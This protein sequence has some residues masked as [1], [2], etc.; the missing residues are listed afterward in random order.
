MNTSLKT[1]RLTDSTFAQ[2]NQQVPFNFNDLS[3]DVDFISRVL[4]QNDKTCV[5]WNLLPNNFKALG[6]VLCYPA[7]RRSLNCHQLQ[8]SCGETGRVT[9]GLAARLKFWLQGLDGRRVG[10]AGGLKRSFRKRSKSEEERSGYTQPGFTQPPHQFIIII[11]KRNILV[12]RDELLIWV[13]GCN[14]EFSLW[15]S[16]CDVSSNPVL[17]W[18]INQRIHFLTTLFTIFVHLK[19]YRNVVFLNA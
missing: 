11:K 13:Y 14:L 5:N 15:S 8:V 18:L 19:S 1:L 12:K 2:C 7:N 9:I 17:Q 16:V 6:S 10:Q 3:N 4:Y